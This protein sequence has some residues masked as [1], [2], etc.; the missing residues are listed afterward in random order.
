MDLLFITALLNSPFSSIKEHSS[1]LFA[2]L[3]Y[4]FAVVFLS[5]IEILCSSQINTFLLG[6]EL[7]VLLLWLILVY[8][9][10]KIFGED[11]F[12]SLCFIQ[13]FIYISIDS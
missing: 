6:K 12:S 11:K 4:G 5:W 7:P 2:R 8:W 9:L 10:I 13:V 1:V 3:A